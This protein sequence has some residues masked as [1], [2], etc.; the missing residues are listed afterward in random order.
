MPEGVGA[1]VATFAELSPLLVAHRLR[2][3]RDDVAIGRMSSAYLFEKLG[4][5]ER[6]LRHVEQVWWIFVAL[7][8]ERGRG[9]EPA[10][11]AAHHFDQLYRIVCGHRFGAARGIHRCQRDEARGAAIAGAVVGI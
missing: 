7:F 3:Y 4:F 9:G 2:Q 1:L 11:I 10:G 8:A 6:A 5:D